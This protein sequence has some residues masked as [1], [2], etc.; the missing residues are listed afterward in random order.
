MSCNRDNVRGSPVRAWHQR[1]EIP[2]RGLPEIRV[3]GLIS[4]VIFLFIVALI[5]F[6]IWS[7]S[8]GH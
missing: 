6:G 2:A 5:V 1:Q 4:L 3:G 8:A 7:M